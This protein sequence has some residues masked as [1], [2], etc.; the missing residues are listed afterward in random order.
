MRLC[1]KNHPVARAR[2]AWSFSGDG[3]DNWWGGLFI[4]QTSKNLWLAIAS[5]IDTPSLAL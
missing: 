1:S 3:W 2:V 4:Q 5:Q